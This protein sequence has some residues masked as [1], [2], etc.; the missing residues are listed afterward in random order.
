MQNRDTILTINV[1]EPALVRAV[2][3]HAQAMG[4]ELK[5]LVLVHKDYA[6]QPGRPKDDSGLFEEVICDFNNPDEIQSALKPY[7]DRLLAATCRYEEAI[8]PFS[9]VI[10]FLPY[11]YTP[12]ETALLW[13][14]QKA[15]MRDRLRNYDKSLVPNYQYLEVEDLPNLKK[16][17]KDFVFPVI[18]KPTGLSKALLV[19]RCDTETE[20]SQR[21]GYTFETIKSVYDREQYPGKPGIL[22]EEMMPGEMYSTDAYVTHDGEI[23]CLPMVRVVTAHSVGLPGGFYGYQR[24]LPTELPK[25]E[26]EG[27]FAASRSAIK[28]LNLSSTTAHVELFRTPEGW[29]IIEVAARIGGYRDTLYREVYGIE[30]FYNDLLVRMGKRPEMP[31]KPIRHAAVL[32]IYADHE[33][34]I[35]SIK[36]LEEAQN[37][38]SIVFLA[39]HAQAGERALFATNGGNPVVDGILSHKDPD[40]LKSDIAQVLSLVKVKLV[41]GRKDEDQIGTNFHTA[42]HADVPTESVLS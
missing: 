27:A 3:L 21:L 38:E 20:L 22:V 4:R 7:A 10:P 34:H 29:K 23:L 1:V 37:L 13:S 35:E 42:D 28:A 40:K 16:L 36:G 25:R 39:A 30:H 18:V 11:L 8:Q 12:S 2:K 19:A 14:T 15:L 24:L 6:D 41:K 31:G 26:V 9:Q 33:G 5:G 32:N 17:V